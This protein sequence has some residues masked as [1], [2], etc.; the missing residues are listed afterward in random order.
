MRK[1]IELKLNDIIDD[2]KTG[3][4]TRIFELRLSTSGGASIV[5]V[6]TESGFKFATSSVTELQ[7]YNESVFFANY[8]N[9][10]K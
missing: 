5:S 10:K 8:G 1:A 6:T 9:A 3:E 4:K 7:T 2:N